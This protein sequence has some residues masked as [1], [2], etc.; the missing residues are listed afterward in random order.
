MKSYKFLLALNLCATPFLASAHNP[1]HAEYATSNF[2][3]EDQQASLR[4]KA[5]RLSAPIKSRADLERFISSNPG[6]PLDKL[7]PIVRANFIDSLVFKKDG[8]AS[9]SYAGLGNFLTISETYKL[10]SLF[11]M[12]SVTP[13]ISSLPPPSNDVEAFLMIKSNA[14]P[15]VQNNMVCKQINDTEFDC[16]VSPNDACDEDTCNSPRN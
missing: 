1:S 15:P 7:P 14:Q 2:T 12:Q 11:G 6:T 8:L 5:E 3:P 4:H 13:E 10:L 9:L 16:Q